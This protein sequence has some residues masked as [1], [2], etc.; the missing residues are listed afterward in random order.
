MKRILMF[1][2]ICT[3]ALSCYAMKNP[4]TMGARFTFSCYDYSNDLQYIPI[5]KK[6]DAW[7]EDWYVIDYDPST[8]TSIIAKYKRTTMYYHEIGGGDITDL[9]STIYGWDQE[10]FIENDTIRKADNVFMIK[11]GDSWEF[12][13][14]SPTMTDCEV[15]CCG[16]T[17]KG[18]ENNYKSGGLDTYDTD[19]G[20]QHYHIIINDKTTTSKYQWTDLGYSYYNY[21]YSESNYSIGSST[22]LI[23][24]YIPDNKDYPEVTYSAYENPIVE[25][26]VGYYFPDVDC[27]DGMGA[28]FIYSTMKGQEKT[29]M[30]PFIFGIN[31]DEGFY[32]K[33]N[34][35][36]LAN[37][38]ISSFTPNKNLISGTPQ[39][40]HMWGTQDIYEGWME[41]YYQNAPAQSG[42]KSPYTLADAWGGN[43]LFV[44]VPYN[45]VYYNNG[46]FASI[47]GW[48]CDNFY[49]PT[50]WSDIAESLSD[51]S[52]P[53]LYMFIGD[54]Q[55]LNGFSIY[56]TKKIYEDVN[57]DGV[58][59]SLDVL[60]VYKF[61]Q[62]STGEEKDMIE[63]V[64]GDGVVNSLDVLKVYKYMQ[65]H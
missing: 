55:Y 32:V 15:T 57:Q 40:K 23:F 16:R 18:K 26:G 58:V 14:C 41:V 9:R 61:M 36:D 31:L 37:M 60:K 62:T 2:A 5:I 33:I 25:E 19:Y 42:A 63:D 59:N 49:S 53:A 56:L 65:S 11:K 48:V 38:T 7:Y 17:W 20:G 51:P 22:E 46:V 39:L 50:Y 43:W 12:F 29:P 34:S 3:M 6:K 35:D 54:E 8:E 64:N 44:F 4:Y 52:F 1:F 10:K 24:A 45:E 21:S 47:W 30:N 27:G 28:L 13:Y